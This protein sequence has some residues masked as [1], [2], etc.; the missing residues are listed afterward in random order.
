MLLPDI[1]G[2]GFILRALTVIFLLRTSERK[3]AG[4]MRPIEHSF[5]VWEWH[6]GKRITLLTFQDQTTYDAVFA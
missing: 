2:V 5:L 4:W 3:R 6:I 1:D